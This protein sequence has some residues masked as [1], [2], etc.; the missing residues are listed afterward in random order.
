MTS[1]SAVG[2][3]DLYVATYS[4]DPSQAETTKF[5]VSIGSGPSRVTDD[6]KNSGDLPTT[7][8]PL[9]TGTPTPTPSSQPYVYR[10]CYTETSTQRAL[11]GAASSDNAMTV[12]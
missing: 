12:E 5:D 2:S 9:G 7:C 8:A 4:L 6:F 10:G 1:Q 3:Y 11:T